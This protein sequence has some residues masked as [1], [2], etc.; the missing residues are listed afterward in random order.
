MLNSIVSGCFVIASL[1]VTTTTTTH[2]KMKKTARQPSMRIYSEDDEMTVNLSPYRNM[3]RIVSEDDERTLTVKRDAKIV[4]ERQERGWGRSEHGSYHDV[5]HDSDASG[6]RS[7]DGEGNYVMKGALSSNMHHLFDARHRPAEAKSSS[8]G[9]SWK[10]P[11]KPGLDNS[12]PILHRPEYR[13]PPT[14][15][16]HRSHHSGHNGGHH[17]HHVHNHGNDDSDD[18]DDHYDEE[19]DDDDENSLDQI[20]NGHD[21]ATLT[22][23]NL[24]PDLQAILGFTP[25]RVSTDWIPP[26]RPGLD[27]SLPIVDRSAQS[28]QQQQQPS[29]SDRRREAKGF[30]GSGVAA[31]DAK[32]AE[33]SSMR[34][35]KV[36]YSPSIRHYQSN[37]SPG[38][39]LSSSR[40]FS[41]RL[42]NDA[43]DGYRY[44]YEA[45]EAGYEDSGG[46][47]RTSPPDNDRRP[48]N[49]HH[50]P[51]P[52]QQHQQ[53]QHRTA[54]PPRQW[55]N[56]TPLV[57]DSDRRKYVTYEAPA[58]ASTSRGSANSNSNSNNHRSHHA[59]N[60]SDF[61]ASPTISA[62]LARSSPPHHLAHQ[63]SY[64]SMEEFPEVY[65]DGDGEAG[66]DEED[67]NDDVNGHGLDVDG[68]E[69]EDEDHHQFATKNM[70]PNLLAALGLA[71]PASTTTTTAPST[72][73]PPSRPGLDNSAPIVVVHKGRANMMPPSSGG[74]AV[75]PSSLS[76]SPSP[77]ASA[78]APFRPRDHVAEDGIPFHPARRKSYYAAEEEEIYL[79]GKEEAEDD[80]EEE[81]EN[82]DEE[83]EHG[84]R[85]GGG[86]LPTNV[87]MSLSLM[88]AL[89]LDT[90]HVTATVTDW[91]PPSRSGLSNS[92]RL[93]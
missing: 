79:E 14:S 45:E 3:N 47:L 78:S 27:N 85:G 81:D 55:D 19:D 11:S 66:A 86:G 80:D 38:T 43:E 68:D 44:G 74:G 84:A 72:W 18:Y 71:P 12:Q 35:T 90:S 48:R 88:Q 93:V 75:G 51:L 69:D 31:A 10:P 16:H 22:M 1:R 41:R 15:D 24:S 2:S 34:S 63:K 29:S 62:Q 61:D 89:G 92:K 8:R 23:S 32:F 57:P 36:N 77:A 70:S 5:D 53:Q 33:S 40:T 13:N 65:N 6:Y 91:Q 59:S 49:D 46:K 39:S 50:R 73:K 21:W 58:V 87:T 76:H 42:N 4:S 52:P 17:R 25:Q 9:S 26:S 54:P 82:E 7:S 83:D 20:D 30:D 37:A 64:W 56:T 28:K 67:D 60:K